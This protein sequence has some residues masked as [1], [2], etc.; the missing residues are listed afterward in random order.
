MIPIFFVSFGFIVL[1]LSRNLLV[2]DNIPTKRDIL[3]YRNVVTIGPVAV[4]SIRKL[5]DVCDFSLRFDIF[6]SSVTH[7]PSSIV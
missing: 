7:G 4:N 5:S 2:L 3:T 1:N 6:I